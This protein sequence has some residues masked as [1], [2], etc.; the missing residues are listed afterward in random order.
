M[1]TA[2][3][4]TRREHDGPGEEQRPPRPAAG[5]GQQAPG[6]EVTE[7]ARR[8]DAA[9][10]TPGSL[11]HQGAGGAAGDGERRGRGARSAARTHAAP[12]HPLI[13]TGASAPWWR[14][15][16]GAADEP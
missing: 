10:G 8:S 1:S 13:R 12:L 16:S 2:I 6:V 14:L 3:R 5:V 7:A 11:R 9:A 15:A 4:R